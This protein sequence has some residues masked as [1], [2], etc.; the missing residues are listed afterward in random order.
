MVRVTVCF[1]C[2]LGAAECHRTSILLHR[3]N[4]VAAGRTGCLSVTRQILIGIAPHL[5]NYH[6]ELAPKKVEAILFAKLP[7]APEHCPT[8][9]DANAVLVLTLQP[10]SLSRMWA[11]CTTADVMSRP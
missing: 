7:V 9:I 1:T 4:I 2:S 8:G 6:G 10:M 3:N 11:R 5:Q